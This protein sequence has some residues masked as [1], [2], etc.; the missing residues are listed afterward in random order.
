MPKLHKSKRYNGRDANVAQNV[1]FEEYMKSVAR[2]EVASFIVQSFQYIYPGKKILS[3]VPT[4][5]V[6]RSRAM[7][8]Y[9]LKMEVENI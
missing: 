1:Y 2:G 7:W 6:T 5:M 9:G 8:D 3:Y 4:G